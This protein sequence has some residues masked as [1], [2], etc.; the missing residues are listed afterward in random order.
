[1]QLAGRDIA[2]RLLISFGVQTQ[3]FFLILL[4]TRRSSV[5]GALAMRKNRP[6]MLSLSKHGNVF[7]RNLLEPGMVPSHEGRSIQMQT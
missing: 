3:K 6:F 4:R 7:F 1:M 2:D 5:S